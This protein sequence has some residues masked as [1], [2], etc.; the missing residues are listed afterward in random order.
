V[1]SSRPP[2][3]SAT[4]AVVVVC[5]ALGVVS[6]AETR[7]VSIAHGA[8]LSWS[9]VIASMMPR[10]L[11]LAAA[12]PLA[13]RLAATPSLR[14]RR[15]TVVLTHVAL[16][17]AL[18]WVHAIVMAVTLAY[19]NPIALLFSWPARLMRAWYSAMPTVVSL[20]AAV[21]AVAWALHEARERER[22]S[23][24]AS[25]L[26]AQLQTAQL[27]T[28][29]ARLQ[30][31]FLYNTLNGITA[32]V[33]D[34]ES[35]KAVAA[36]EQ[37]SELLRASLRDDGRD[38]VSVR[39]EVA[40]AERYLALQQMRFGDRLSHAVSLAPA[41]AE[42]TVPVLLL[43]PLVENAVVHG[44][45]SGEG[46]LHVAIF[47]VPFESGVE[48]RVENDGAG[49]D[50]S[51]RIDGVGLAATR[52]R[53]STAYGDRASLQLLPR[54]GGGVVVQLILPRSAAVEAASEA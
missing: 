53:L 51:K 17:L 46:T 25:Q 18:S 3:R 39:E 21:L 27:A 36:I 30:P 54:V 6:A 24:R 2:L 37:L 9:A 52:A 32:L 42:C 22:R 14:S 11:L 20:Y 28:L 41:V 34:A 13:L 23:V 26:E 45:A 38:V 16:F 4:L 33:V 43:Q 49:L 8:P 44:L 7:H 50:A 35:T 10:W 40:L 12:L 1:P 29:R 5:L 31:H 47:A 48:V 19:A 15:R